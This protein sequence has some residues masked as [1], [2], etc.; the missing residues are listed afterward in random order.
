MSTERKF[1]VSN[2]AYSLL[3]SPRFAVER[4][5]QLGINLLKNE[6]TVLSKAD[7]MALRADLVNL[8]KKNCIH[9]SLIEVAKDMNVSTSLALK[10]HGDDKADSTTDLTSHQATVLRNRIAANFAKGKISLIK[11]EVEYPFDKMVELETV[12]AEVSVVTITLDI[13]TVERL[14]TTMRASD[15]HDLD[16]FAHNLQTTLNKKGIKPNPWFE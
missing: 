12:E 8:D 4:A 2:V 10:L 15:I 7:E 9:N 5:K 13:A 6:E 14:I 11:Q 16:A 1:S 3:V